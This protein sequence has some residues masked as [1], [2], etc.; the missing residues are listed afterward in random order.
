LVVGW[1]PGRARESGR[2]QSESK[3]GHVYFECVVFRL[4]REVSEVRVR[5][6]NVVIGVGPAREVRSA[7]WNSAQAV[8]V[9]LFP[10]I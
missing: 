4:E 3:Q 5:E 1:S 10:E 9:A 2:K 6:R 8:V 7:D